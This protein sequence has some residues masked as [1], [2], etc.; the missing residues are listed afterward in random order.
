[1]LSISVVASYSSHSRE[2][3]FRYMGLICSVCRQMQLLAAGP[4]SLSSATLSLS[5]LLIL[6]YGVIRPHYV[7]LRVAADHSFRLD[8]WSTD[9]HL[10]LVTEMIQFPH[11][12]AVVRTG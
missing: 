1:M 10:N 5:M 2:F 8:F 4:P 9:R 7:A 3:A 11:N 12:M 6:S